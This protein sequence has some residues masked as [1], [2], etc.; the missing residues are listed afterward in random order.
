MPIFIGPKPGWTG[1]VLAARP[2][3]AASDL[4]KAGGELPGEAKAY[5]PESSDLVGA[6]EG[7]EGSV[8][9]PVAL[10]GAVKAPAAIKPALAGKPAKKVAQ[11]RK[12]R[13][14]GKSAPK[15]DKKAPAGAV[16]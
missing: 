3:D 14:T 5:A 15:D 2:T 11:V 6:A 4:A 8:S 12:V 9:A 1:P 7:A 13:K 16:D 10:Q